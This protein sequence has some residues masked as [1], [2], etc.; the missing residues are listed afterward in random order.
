MGVEV[1]IIVTEGEICEEGLQNG[2]V[3]PR[4][5]WWMKSVYRDDDVRNLIHQKF[6]ERMQTWVDTETEFEEWPKGTDYFD[7]FKN[8]STRFDK[9][10]NTLV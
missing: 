10:S 9:N 6:H 2:I 5:N 3:D 4:K 7:D 1:R 8:S